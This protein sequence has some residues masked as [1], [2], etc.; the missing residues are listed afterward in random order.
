MG[1]SDVPGA[2]KD[3]SLLS[4]RLWSRIDQ[5]RPWG[6]SQS[7]TLSC[8]HTHT[9]TRQTHVHHSIH[10]ITVVYAH[11]QPPRLTYPRAHVET[12]IPPSPLCVL[13]QAGREVFAKPEIIHRLMSAATDQTTLS[14]VPAEDW[15]HGREWQNISLVLPLLLGNACGIWGLKINLRR[16]KQV[17][18]SL[19]VN[20]THKCWEDSGLSSQLPKDSTND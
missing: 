11:R 12:Y 8:Q 10:V 6:E 17:G 16:R 20:F 19:S 7:S 9:H 18:R 2:L 13:S 4:Q 14:V 5:H 3:S 1:E 15:S